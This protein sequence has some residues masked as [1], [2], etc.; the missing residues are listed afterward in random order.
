MAQTLLWIGLGNIGRVSRPRSFETQN[1][2]PI[3]ICELT[4]SGYV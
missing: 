3:V 1:P 2:V 4:S